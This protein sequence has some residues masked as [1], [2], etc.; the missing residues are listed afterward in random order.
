MQIPAPI[1]L[2]VTRR[3]VKLRHSQSS[4]DEFSAAADDMFSVMET[5]KQKKYPD[6]YFIGTVAFQTTVTSELCQP[7]AGVMIMSC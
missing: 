1:A 5:S 4:K 3:M 2:A 7:F 6:G